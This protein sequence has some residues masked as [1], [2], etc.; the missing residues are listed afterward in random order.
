VQPGGDGL[1]KR[2]F[3]PFSCLTLLCGLCGSALAGYNIVVVQS[4]DVL[5]YEEALN[6]FKSICSGPVTRVVLSEMGGKDPA[7]RIEQMGPDLVLA[8]GK[9]GLS[10]AADLRGIPVISV[11]VTDPGSV[12]SGKGNIHAVRM[13]ISPDKELGILLKMLPEIR[14]IGILYDPEK[15]DHLF[16]DIKRAARKREIRLVA[17]QVPTAKDIP[18]LIKDMKGRIDLF[19][20]LPDT[21]VIRPESVQFIFLSFLESRIPILT[22]SKKYLDLGALVSI[23][24]DAYDMGRQAGD[25]AN[26]ILSSGLTERVLCRWMREKRWFRSMSMW[27]RS[28]GSILPMHTRGRSGL[29]DD[30]KSHQDS[31]PQI[32]PQGV[33]CGFSAHIC[34]LLF[35]YRP[36]YL[37]GEQV[38]GG[39]PYE[40]R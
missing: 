2:L 36:L 29:P 8:I 9:G 34:Y 13:S 26:R 12:L 18:S 17:K 16:E 25:M 19:W 3:M 23:S 33:P 35:L 37:C 30:T 22:F 5:P 4:I 39:R 24:M 1:I 10:I 40:K 15:S 21:T 28:W 20:M 11:M 6:G 32:R 27:Q 31:T 7:N 14:V 38:P